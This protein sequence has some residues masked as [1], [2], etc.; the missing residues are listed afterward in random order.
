MDER[1]SVFVAIVGAGMSGIT[2]AAQILKQNALTRDEFKIFD[3]NDDYGGVWQ[4]N[5]YP[6]AACDVPSHAYVLRFHLKPD[7]SKEY[8]EQAEIQ[9]YYADVAKAYRLRESTV[10]S[11]KVI[12]ATWNETTLKY[13][14]VVMDKKTGK[15]SEWTANVVINAGGQ[16]SKPKYANIPGAKDFKGEQWH[17]SDWHEGMDV[18][19]KRVAIIG[20]GPSTAQV[21]P[22]IAPLT[23]E[24]TIYQRSATYCMPR[25]DH[26]H[27]A[28][29]I[30]LFKWLPFTLYI[31][32]IWWYLSIEG[33]KKMWLSGTKENAQMR[34]IAL[35]HLE[36]KVKD[37]KT[38]QKLTPQHEFGCKRILILDDWYPMF[39]RP[40]VK[41][42][43]DRPVK[44]TE[45]GI[46]SKP[47]GEV[48]PSE[49]QEKPGDAWLENN[50]VED[51]QSQE[52]KIDV[53][54]WGT[55]FDMTHQGSH[56]QLYGLGGVSLEELWGDSPR[57]YYSVAVNKFPNFMMMLGPNSANFWSNLTTLV[58]IQAKYN[59]QL[60]KRIKAECD[61]NG[62]YAMNVTAEAQDAYNKE[63]Q[64]KMGNIAILSPGCNNYYTNSTG[65]ATYWGPLRGWVYAWRLLWPKTNHYTVAVD[66]AVTN[67]DKPDEKSAADLY[68]ANANFVD[69]KLTNLPPLYGHCIDDLRPIKVICI[70]AGFSGILAGIR[71]PQR[72]PN[73]DFTIYEKNEEVGGTWFENRYPGV[74]CDVPSAAYQYTF[75]S[76]TQWSEYYCKGGEINEYLK[77]TAHKYGVYK[78][79]KFKTELKGATW[80]EDTGKWVVDLQ[81]LLTG[82]TF[83][84]DCDFLITATG[85]LNKWKWPSIEGRESYT[86]RMVHSANW[87]PDLTMDKIK[88]KKVALIGAGSSGIQILPQIQPHA[89]V[90]DHYMASQTWISPIGFGSQELTDRGAIGN[91]KHSQE[92]LDSFRDN[93]EAYAKFRS[94]VEKMVNAAALVT[95]HGSPLQQN[96]QAIN[97]EAMANKLAKK[98]EIMRVLEPSWPPG[99]R[100]LTPGPGYL[101][102]LVEDNVNFVSTKI[103]RFTANGIETVDGKT[104]DVDLVICATGFD[105]T[106]KGPPLVG[107]GGRELN[108]VWEPYPKS[109]WGICPPEMPNMFRFIGPNGASGT[110]GLIHLLECAC[111]FMIRVVQKA[112]RE[113]IMSMM[114]KMEVIDTFTEHVDLYFTK[115]IYTQPCKSW[116]KRGKEDGRVITIWP[117]SALHA[118]YAYENPRW[119]DFE[120]THHK[121]AQGNYMAWLGNGLTMLQER[122]EHTT[123]Y[124]DTV[125]KPPVI[126]ELDDHSS[127]GV[128]RLIHDLVAPDGI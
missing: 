43:T 96:F 7:W 125:D 88:G 44:I 112:Q 100:R 118:A 94:K 111:E 42:I 28:W 77:R 48:K 66:M 52:T 24:L 79:I 64:G 61:T 119:E 128:G 98:P 83:T 124:L 51:A 45:N 34:D 114:P 116:M 18:K 113:Y 107:R 97:R 15:K 30:N 16:F 2:M 55:G 12:S 90:V 74:R 20:T 106:C 120:Y 37:P 86:G 1:K 36:S 14:M 58:E 5:Q 65:E 105:T 92:E 13:D 109:Y 117:G 95:L 93:P 47:P 35:A 71:F 32:H 23:K 33:R 76:N 108:D 49:N 31:Y 60:I 59:V 122:N 53:L 50:V 91:F 25:Q 63:I 6:G 27:P 75:E 80:Q 54:I 19:G 126:N 11:T 46:V 38:R 102:A 73:L 67:G 110:G 56:F 29:R 81:N 84:D 87:D 72:V 121:L 9:Q 26:P 21:A 8:A 127:N 99:C 103:K 82:E 17:T 4:A 57:A 3:G 22:R 70:G 40:N 123:E 69:P 68:A 41:L 115:T 78:Y 85:I 101:E 10:F 39:N 89:E 104:R 62:P